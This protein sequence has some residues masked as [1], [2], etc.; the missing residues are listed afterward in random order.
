MH[1]RSSDPH[2]PSSRPSLGTSRPS[3]RS[4]PVD[5][6]MLEQLYG[7]GPGAPPPPHKRSLLGGASRT[8]KL[9]LGELG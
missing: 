4:G 9:V 7:T 6:A 8:L 5:E 1:P 3:S 2:F